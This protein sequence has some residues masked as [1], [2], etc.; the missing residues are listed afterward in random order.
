[1]IHVNSFN[2]NTNNMKPQLQLHCM[3]RN[4]GKHFA[5][6][7]TM[8]S[9]V[10]F[11]YGQTS[12]TWKLTGKGDWANSKNWT[13]KPSGGTF[14]GDNGSVTDTAYINQGTAVINSGTYSVAQ[15]TMYAYGNYSGNLT[16]SS[17]ATLNVVG[18][19]TS[20]A[21]FQ[22]YPAATALDTIIN[23]GTLNF[24][25]SF[26]SAIVLGG[27]TGSNQVFT[28]S[29]NLQINADCSGSAFSY[30][31]TGV[32]Y[33]I[34]NSG[35]MN[36]VNTDTGKIATLSSTSGNLIFTNTGSISLS[37]KGR[38]AFGGA[39]C[40]FNNSG[41]F[42]TDM[43]FN[44]K[45]TFNNLTNGVLTFTGLSTASS[46][47]AM[48]SSV[49]F[50]NQGGTLNSAPGSK[51]AIG[52]SGVNTFTSGTISPGGSSIGTMTISAVAPV[53][54]PMALKDTIR[55]QVNGDK[56]AGTDY[57]RLSGTGGLSFNIGGA[58][59]DV[60]GIF[61]PSKKDTIIILAPGGGTIQGTINGVFASVIGLTSGWSIDYTSTA[62]KLVYNP[63]L[64]VKL[65]GFSAVEGNGVNVLSWETVTETNN[66]GFYIQRQTSNGGWSEIGFVAANGHASAYSFKDNFTLTTSFYRLLQVDL[67]GKE[68]ISQVVSVIKNKNYKLTIS[69]NPTTDKVHITLPA[70]NNST[71]HA[72]VGVYDFSGKQVL[73]KQVTNNSVDLDFSTFAKG[74]YIVKVVT[75]DNLY[76]EK[77]VRK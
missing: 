75:N 4:L 42:S 19:S 33:S 60:T 43:D 8:M 34:N 7:L 69:P 5:L 10:A 24:T 38:V 73:S 13:S 17:G 9:V 41:S 39:T 14:P 16:I 74:T 37:G 56:T 55:I 44:C 59:L 49:V 65:V 62:V 11:S 53:T 47:N 35:T 28:N 50:N 12:Y 30:G 1:M 36:V 61:T 20:I 29:G 40:V 58:T 46:Y 18:G 15:I 2:F 70:N 63:A 66:K 77:V 45:G 22:L 64:P 54:S 76:C 48:Q 27:K 68:S 31:S 26:S 23:N 32:N 57:D 51:N 52:I 21:G 72:E 6:L 67:D 71:N 25:G 3:K